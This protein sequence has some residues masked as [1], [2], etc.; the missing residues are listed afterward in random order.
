MSALQ[1]IV[2]IDSPRGTLDRGW[3]PSGV[4]RVLNETGVPTSRVLVASASEL[5][6]EVQTGT[7]AI[8]W[9]LTYTFD[10]Q[11]TGRTIVAELAALRA[12]FLT[13]NPDGAQLTSKLRF[14]HAVRSSRLSTPGWR[15]LDMPA[16]AEG[17]SRY[18]A[19]VKSEFSCGSAGVRIAYAGAEATKLA[20]ELG[21]TFGHRI[22]LEAAI[23]GQEW[24]VACIV[25]EDFTM[26]AALS[27]T[28]RSAE[29]IDAA[30]KADNSL[31]EFGLPSP[32]ESQ[33]LGA[34]ARSLVARL[35]LSG[36]FRVDLLASD[37]G[38]LQVIDLNILPCLESHMA[39]LS[40]VPMAFMRNT[41]CSYE[42]V[43]GAVIASA[44]RGG[45]A[46]A[47]HSPLE[48][49]VQRSLLVRARVAS[50]A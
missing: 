5:N 31:I 17:W 1:S 24:S 35:G 11:P 50:S 39:R 46:L 42:D 16:D 34:F 28:A 37:V 14:K 6:R 13:C 18:P 19:F 9:P 33:T 21:R 23:T 32:D 30:A 45:R 15:E 47:E 48:D 22:F 36:Y 25:T 3:D 20:D 27:F 40:Y 10:G 8:F 44:D 49:L 4:L 7:G 26:T 38:E 41:A 29:Y 2:F 43:L 12:P